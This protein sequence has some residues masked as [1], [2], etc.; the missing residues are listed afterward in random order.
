M[1]RADLIAQ[2]QTMAA[3]YKR[4]AAKRSKNPALAA[5]LLEWSAASL[6]RAETLRC[7]PLFKGDS[8]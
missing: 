4:E 6:R 1:S 2:E 8:E 7:G 5:Q 3:T